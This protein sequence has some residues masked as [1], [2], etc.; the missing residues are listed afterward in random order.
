MADS[1]ITSNLFSILDISSNL[2]NSSSH[3]AGALKIG[4]F[5]RQILNDEPKK[6]EIYLHGSFA[7]THKGHGTDKAIIAGIMNFS[8]DDERIKQSLEIA[9][10]IDL[11]FSFILEDLG[12]CHPNTAK[13]ILEGKDTKRHEIIGESIG[14]GEIVI[15]SIDGIDV[16]ITTKMYNLI[17]SHEDR[18]GLISKVI[19]S[20]RLARETS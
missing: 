16:S 17:V 11:D 18:L 10:D 12:N 2:V 6:A 20:P 19:K 1:I 9:N 14:G 8:N 13:I 15:T 5:A 7:K 4:A 3:T